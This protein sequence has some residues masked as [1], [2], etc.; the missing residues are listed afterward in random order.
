[1]PFTN[2]RRAKIRAAS[3]I[4]IVLLSH[5]SSLS[6]EPLVLVFTGISILFARQE[7]ITRVHGSPALSAFV[8]KTRVLRGF[9]CYSF[10]HAILAFPLAERFFIY[11][12]S[13]ELTRCGVD[14]KRTCI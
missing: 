1:M 6:W 5:L 13:R 7:R 3:L 4:L 11:R 14:A 2:A 8:P 9:E 12:T 10:G